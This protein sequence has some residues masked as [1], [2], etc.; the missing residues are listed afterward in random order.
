[1]TRRT[2]GHYFQRNRSM[3]QFLTYVELSRSVAA[4]L[5]MPQ[6]K[7]YQKILAHLYW[8]CCGKSPAVN[9]LCTIHSKNG[10]SCPTTM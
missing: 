3:L 7:A 9:K 4:I 8:Y 5:E 2:I 10:L 6:Y 1:M